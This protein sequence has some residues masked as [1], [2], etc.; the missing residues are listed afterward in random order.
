VWAAVPVKDLASAKSRL[1]GVI[2]PA[3]RR[4]L[5]LTWLGGVLGALRES[6][7]IAR[8][9]VVSADPEVL[10]VAAV[11][12]AEAVREAAPA[13]LNAAV[14]QAAALASRGGAEGLL[15]M[16]ADLPEVGAADV[17]ALLAAGAAL[18]GPGV[19]LAPDHTGRGTNA[20][21]LRPPTA[22]LPRFGPD[23]FAAHRWA[24]LAA[25]L[26]ARIVARPGPAADVDTPG[27]L[28]RMGLSAVRLG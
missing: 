15:V 17:A 19:V 27:D 6:G 3:R 8:I 10:G 1:S 9:L 21:L 2:A 24:A 18:D 4:A 26:P 5:T 14:G 25:G 23:S 13:G 16:A 22:I 12:G 11:A 7:G 20:L 28:E